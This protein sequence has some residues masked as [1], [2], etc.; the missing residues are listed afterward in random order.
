MEIK[1]TE[2]ELYRILDWAISGKSCGSRY[3]GMTYED[4]IVYTL[5]RILGRNDEAPD[6][7]G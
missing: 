7:D 6:S 3:P 5:D 4:G 2:D 1:R